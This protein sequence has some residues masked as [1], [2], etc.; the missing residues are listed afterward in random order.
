[1]TEASRWS[2]FPSAVRRGSQMN[3][4]P[5]VSRADVLVL[6]MVVLVVG[7]LLLAAVS[8]LREVAAAATCQN[9]LKQL[10]ISTH[11]YSDA[12]GP[13]PPLVD[14]GEGAPTGRGL[15]SLFAN[16]MPYIE[17]TYLVFRPERPVGYYH[18]HSSVE[19]TYPHK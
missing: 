19:F 6:V 7:G 9:N 10:G 2:A 14:Q 15:P 16:L 11:S 17:A 1:M 13:L 4:R 3:Q 18:A 5:G 8:R 12:L